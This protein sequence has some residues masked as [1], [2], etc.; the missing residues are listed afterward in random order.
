MMMTSMVLMMMGCLCCQPLI[1]HSRI[2]NCLA[3][4]VLLFVFVILASRSCIRSVGRLSPAPSLKGANK[5]CRNFHRYDGIINRKKLFRVRFYTSVS[6]CDLFV[7]AGVEDQKLHSADGDSE[8]R[9]WWWAT[10][11]I[12]WRLRHGTAIENRNVKLPNVCS[13]QTSLL[14]WRSHR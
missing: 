4:M 14:K 6:W 11:R 2:P 10:T 8:C 13:W 3:A 9:R 5:R 7:P 12:P 1:L